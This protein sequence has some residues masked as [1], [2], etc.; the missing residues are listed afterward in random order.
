M[1][2]KNIA[3]VKNYTVVQANDL[4]RNKKDFSLWELR[5]FAMLAS[6]VKKEDDDFQTYKFRIKDLLDLFETKSH[7]LYDELKTIPDKLHAKLIRIPYED[8]N[9]KKRMRKYNLISMSDVP[10]GEDTDDSD[11]ILLRFDKDLKPL[12]LS[13]GEHFTVYKFYN[14]LKLRSPYIFQLYEL[15]KSEEYRGSNNV[16][17]ST[18]EFIDIL[19]IPA[20]YKFGNIKQRILEP[21]KKQFREHTDII[22]EYLPV[23]GRGGK[24]VSLS[25]RIFKNKQMPAILIDSEEAAASENISTQEQLS[26][27][28]K[29]DSA[30]FL[31]LYPKVSK[32]I[33]EKSFRKL[34]AENSE[35]Q[36]SQAV[37]YT[38]NRLKK[39]NKIDNI[40]G[41]IVAM[42]K[43]ATLFDATENKKTA[44]KKERKEKSRI[45]DK[46]EKLRR[47]KKRIAEELFKKQDT[48]MEGIFLEIPGSK[49]AIF[50]A[51]KA[52]KFSYYKAELSD[53]E[54][55]NNAMFRAAFRTEFKKKY[56]ERFEALD[57]R[58]EAK[59]KSINAALNML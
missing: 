2:K 29:E 10:D 42:T 13:L 11:H 37:K 23:K 12:M 55:M 41:H 58:Y 35:E 16:E 26:D 18:E 52:H 36:V 8:E 53:E 44:A 49:D 43:Q 20:S 54:N 39:G 38:L 14:I 50:A 31:E 9:G 22:F 5:V 17:I 4:I 28:Q 21:A 59:I 48:I 25:F 27:K 15:L 51:A 1:A 24:I 32:W 34:L 47:E 33:N 19:Q 57:K 46:K 30:V 40:A 3:K 56:K 45:N 6:H 7:N